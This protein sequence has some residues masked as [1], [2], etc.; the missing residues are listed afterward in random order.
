M[1]TIIMNEYPWIKAMIIGL[2]GI[3]V[4]TSKE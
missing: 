1:I 4:L 3:M 2:L